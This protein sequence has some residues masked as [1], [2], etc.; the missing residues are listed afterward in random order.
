M[1]D[2]YKCH[3]WGLGAIETFN[4]VM[5]M[6]NA[7]DGSALLYKFPPDVGW[8]FKGLGASSRT[9]DDDG[10]VWIAIDTCFWIP[11]ELPESIPSL[12]KLYPETN[13]LTVFWL[14]KEFGWLNDVKFRDET[15]GAKAKNT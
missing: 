10:N 1:D 9:L 6:F 8:G 11:E 4:G 12:A 5:V 14:P 3:L 15:F 13:T 7:T 2:L